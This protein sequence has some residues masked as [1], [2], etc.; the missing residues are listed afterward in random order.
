M[1]TKVVAK[2]AEAHA[3]GTLQSLMKVLGALF[4]LKTYPLYALIEKILSQEL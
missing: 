2:A 4:P 1:T 3:V